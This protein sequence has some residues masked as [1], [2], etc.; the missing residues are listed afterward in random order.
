MIASKLRICL[1]ASFAATL[2]SACGGS[3]S[4][5]E[6]GETLVNEIEAKGIDGTYLFVSYQSESLDDDA[7]TDTQPKLYYGTQNVGTQSSVDVRIANRGADIYPLNNV[8]VIGDNADEFL[9]D[10][11]DEIILQPAEFVNINVAFQPITA[12]EKSADF[13]VDYDTIKMV[14]EE[15]NVNEQS[16]YEASELEAA[17]QFRSARVAYE[18]YLANDPVTINER[19]AALKLP[20]I[21]E[22]Q[23][24]ASDEELQ[25]YLDAMSLRDYEEY[26]AAIRKLNVLVSL[27]PES[28]LADDAQYLKGYIQL[29]D[30]DAPA[31]ALLS[32]QAVRSSFPDTT[33]YD[34]SLYSEA[35]AHIELGDTSQA[36]QI[37]L[38]LKASHT[39]IE[40]LGIQLPKDNLVSRMWFARAN[41]ALGSV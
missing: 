12:G 25:L 23:T 38:D 28:Y 16:Y 13:T 9:T 8:A 34:T 17:G 31:D 4:D 21:D 19:R 18:D 6:T 40:A 24:Y 29:I 5:T 1:C 15:V 27:Y 39:G 30:L 33:Y 35:M 14:N 2:L 26:D 32:M 41:E 37:L 20:V 11:V 10:V 7:D 22:G 36:E 3:G